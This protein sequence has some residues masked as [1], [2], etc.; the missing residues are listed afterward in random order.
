MPD[1][2]IATGALGTKWKQEVMFIVLCH[3]VIAIGQC[4]DVRIGKDEDKRKAR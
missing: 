2:I 4:V 3:S 1:R